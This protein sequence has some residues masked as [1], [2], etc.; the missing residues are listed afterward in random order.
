[1]KCIH[2]ALLILISS[3]SHAEQDNNSSFSWLESLSV[4]Y[5]PV[6]EVRVL[7][8][9]DTSSVINTSASD[10]KYSSLQVIETQINSK[11]KTKYLIEYDEGLSVDPVFTVYEKTSRG[12]KE[13]RRFGCTEIVIPGNGNVYISGH[14]NNMFN[15]RRK[16]TLTAVGFEEV[17]QPYMYVGISTQI[18]QPI[19]LY[20]TQKMEGEVA[21]LPKGSEVEVLLND[22]IYYLV[23]TSYGLLGWYDAS[24][25]CPL[26]CNSEN[27][28]PGIFN[29][30]D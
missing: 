19:I 13:I 29:N 18:R 23:K 17:V 4:D 15:Q 8:N 12:L 11:S 6:G 26:G 22:G 2:L 9:K 25:H 24:S 27:P 3:V 1:M 7:Y 16:F 21:K 10:E 20:A 14:T 5:T 30:G 28:I